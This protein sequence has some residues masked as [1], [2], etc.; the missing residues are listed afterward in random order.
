M[1]ALSL[2]I[3]GASAILLGPQS[4]PTPAA[5]SAKFDGAVHDVMENTGVPSA[6]VGVVQN[7]RVIFTRAYGQARLAPPLPATVDMHYAVG[8]ISK[9]FTAAC[10]LLL[11][12]ARKL[13]LDDPVGK[14]FPA[15]TRANDV[16]IRHLLSH[17][18]GYED[19]APQDYTIPAW[20]KPTT[21]EAIVREWATKPLDFEPGSQYQYSN[22]NFN[23]LGLVVEHV[24]GEPFWTFLSR[25]VLTPLGM[26]HT[27]DLDSDHD[28][29]EP[30]GYFRH[31]LG[32]L[33]PAIMEARGWYFA[34]GEMAMPVGDLL[35]WDISVIARS[36]L[37]PASYTAMETEQRL[38]TGETAHYGLG[39]SLSTR[40]GHRLLS[41]GGEVGGF[42]AQNMVFPDDKIAIAVLT[43]QEAS[44]AASAIARRIA[45][46]LLA[47]TASQTPSSDRAR[48]E[49][50]AEEILGGLQER[51][52]DRAQFTAN[53]NFYFDQ[54]ALD[55]YAS[56]LKP[57]G[58]VASVTQTDTSL[59]GGM[60]FRSFTVVFANGAKLRLTTYTTPSGKLEQ[61]LVGPIG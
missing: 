51:K 60:T 25:N 38:T 17:T 9:Q 11:Q 15:L 30:T 59:R 40:G 16:K 52:I 26:T 49:T 36:L 50:Q 35:T 41:H 39:V 4:P 53:G 44:T 27:I 45:D 37:K 14:Y 56:S 43:N 20:T 28:K 21:A 19:Y 33:R 23:I 7:G 24:S 42:V 29:L 1:K 47:P 61:F 46:L 34:D 3:A 58:A 8:S 13:S 48:A 22:T 6:A 12:E 2:A 54:I 32:P 55:D 31:A 18:S 10:V 57:L 5:Q